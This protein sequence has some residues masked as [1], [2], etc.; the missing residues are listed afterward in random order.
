[1]NLFYRPFILASAA[2]ALLSMF[3]LIPQ[4]PDSFQGVGINVKSAG[5][6]GDLQKGSTGVMASGCGAAPCTVTDSNGSFTAGDVGKAFAMS[7]APFHAPSMPLPC[8][9]GYGACSTT[10]WAV[11]TS[12]GTIAGPSEIHAKFYFTNSSGKLIGDESFEF[13]KHLAG[14]TSNAW[15]VIGFGGGNM[16]SSPDNGATGVM[17]YI[18]ADGATDWPGKTSG[19]EVLANGLPTCGNG[20]PIVN[21]GGSCIVTALPV[22]AAS[23]TQNFAYSTGAMITDTNNNVEIACSTVGVGNC[24]AGGGTSNNSAQPTWP[25]TVETTTSDG[26]VTWTMIGPKSPPRTNWNFGTI[27]SVTNATTIGVSFTS[28]SYSI[29]NNSYEYGTD[30]TAAIQGALNAINASAGGSVFFP[31]GSYWIN[32]TGLTVGTSSPVQFVTLNGAGGAGS[33]LL[34]QPATNNNCGVTELV[35]VGNGSNPLL[36]AGVGGTTQTNGGIHIHDL[37]FRDGSVSLRQ[38]G[39]AGNSLGVGAVWLK[40]EARVQIDDVSCINWTKGYCL[41]FDAGANGQWSQ[42][43][44]IY[45]LNAVNVNWAILADDGRQSDFNVFGGNFISANLGGGVCVDLQSGGSFGGGGNSAFWRFHCNYFPLAIHTVDNNVNEFVGIHAEQT[46]TLDPPACVGIQCVLIGSNNTGTG[47]LL[48]GTVAGGGRCQSNQ[49][50]GGSLTGFAI[51]AQIGLASSNDFC[52]QTFLGF[53]NA[54]N[55]INI[56]DYSKY[57]NGSGVAQGGV[58]T[59]WLN[60][61]FWQNQQAFFGSQNGIA[62][63]SQFCTNPGVYDDTCI[64]NAI[65]FLNSK[66][67]QSNLLFIDGGHNYTIANPIVIGN[68]STSSAYSAIILPGSQITVNV[69]N[70]ADAIQVGE[71]S[72]LGG[73]KGQTASG[74]VQRGARIVLSSTANVNNVINSCSNTGSQAGMG[75]HDLQIAGNATA[76]IANAALFV[77]CLSKGTYYERLTFFSFQAQ[78]VLVKG[79]STGSTNG[80]HFNDITIVNNASTGSKPLQLTAVTPSGNFG[81]ISDAYFNNTFISGADN[82]GCGVTL[83]GNSAGATNAAQLNNVAFDGLTINPSAATSQGVCETDVSGLHLTHYNGLSSVG[84]NFL[85]LSNSLSTSVNITIEN[86]HHVSWTNGINDTIHTLTFTNPNIDRWTLGGG[87]LNNVPPVYKFADPLPASDNGTIIYCADCKNV[88]DD[89]VT[90]DSTAASGGHGTTLLRENGVWRVH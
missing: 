18:S 83:T 4:I 66:V 64:T 31:K 73:Y 26:T 50:I 15:E 40:N 29:T 55:T 19:A 49:F 46:I 67:S 75:L 11:S 22:I 60:D 43:D 41:H 84:T 87:L 69:T 72:S 68:C 1:M 80:I 90:F 48:E 25:T 39:G 36:T 65:T 47:I 61:L 82:V 89:A 32:S 20:A 45:F 38:G 44:S 81:G 77:S 79:C 76:T 57:T 58:D 52:Q 85:K 7:L 12:T 56:Q 8:T 63:A 42:F 59:Q 74:A 24:A 88:T 78:T 17:V 21:A 35:Q 53:T 9:G 27:S 34:G 70:G 14:T 3:L 5:A 30:D 62:F 37:C 13:A 54:N 6:R 71:G 51:G 23:W 28:Q 10:G 86:S 2:V 16:L 33:K